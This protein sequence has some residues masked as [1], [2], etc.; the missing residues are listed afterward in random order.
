MDLL[1]KK[2]KQLLVGVYNC[3]GK[4]IDRE[5]NFKLGAGVGCGGGIYLQCNVDL[6]VD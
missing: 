4:V 6:L 2:I 3:D 1:K 5:T